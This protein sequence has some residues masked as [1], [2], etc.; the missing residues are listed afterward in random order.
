MVNRCPL[1]F[2]QRACRFVP[3]F[4]GY[5]VGIRNQC[6]ALNGHGSLEEQDSHHQSKHTAYFLDF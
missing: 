4:W 2:H 1:I 3:T 5:N 6:E